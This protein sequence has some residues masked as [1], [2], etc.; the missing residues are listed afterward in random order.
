[1]QVVD[2]VYAYVVKF[3]IALLIV[4]AACVA[5][6]E[7]K[8]DY[9]LKRMPQKSQKSVPWA[10]QPP[11]KRSDQYMDEYETTEE[12]IELDHRPV[13]S[14]RHHQAQLQDEYHEE[15][16]VE[17]VDEEKE[18]QSYKFGF[19]IK[20]EHEGHQYR[21]E[22]KDSKGNIH[23]R[24]GYRD[25]K[26]Q[27][28]QVD[29]VA[30]NHGFRAN[31]KTN[32]PGVID[33]NPANVEIQ[34]DKNEARNSHQID[35]AHSPDQSA[36]YNHEK[37]T[38]SEQYHR[39][40]VKEAQSHGDGA[41][42]ETHHD[43]SVNYEAHSH[44]PYPNQEPEKHYPGK[45]EHSSKYEVGPTA[46][47]QKYFV[48]EGES[49]HE[50]SPPPK[51]YR[52]ETAI[53]EKSHSDDTY[54]KRHPK[55]RKAKAHRRRPSTYQYELDTNGHS[56]RYTKP[57]SSQEYE[58]PQEEHSYHQY[59]KEYLG[60][61]H[62]Q[63]LQNVHVAP[64]REKAPAAEEY[65]GFKNLF[66]DKE[67]EHQHKRVILPQI[68]EQDSHSYNPENHHSQDISEHGYTPKERH[69]VKYE[70]SDD[71]VGENKLRHSE[72][73]RGAP[74]HVPAVN[75]YIQVIEE[76]HQPSPDVY[77][78]E[79]FPYEHRQ[80]QYLKTE[81][82]PQAVVLMDVRDKV[83]NPQKETAYEERNY[84][85]PQSNAYHVIQ[86]NIPVQYEEKDEDLPKP[87]HQES[88]RYNVKTHTQE[89]LKEAVLELNADVYKQLIENKSPGR[90]V[91]IPINHLNNGHL[92]YTNSP[93]SHLHPKPGKAHGILHIP[94]DDKSQS[95][96]DL[97]N[98]PLVLQIPHDKATNYQKPQDIFKEHTS[99]NKAP[100]IYTHNQPF[101]VSVPKA[102]NRYQKNKEYSKS[103]WIPMTPSWN[104][105]RR[106]SPHENDSPV[107]QSYEPQELGVPR[108]ALKASNGE[109]Y[110]ILQGEN[111]EGLSDLHRTPSTLT[112]I[113]GSRSKKVK[114]NL[115]TLSSSSALSHQGQRIVSV[116]RS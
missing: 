114:P 13:D 36:G 107:A 93:Q 31:I 65:E 59:D 17:Y 87:S 101:V 75:Q 3:S 78:K 109:V 37:S 44:H 62:G 46:V 72:V 98:L 34:K 22:Q 85:H 29:Y 94:L 97:K 79:K 111:S 110:Q 86:P 39:Q 61:S 4:N 58:P 8:I 88:S 76:P 83:H 81:P 20:D 67:G 2:M 10:R 99:Q 55:N 92:D 38:E 77:D 64:T 60:H 51:Q 47:V 90:I 11:E 69:V 18:P 40:P 32:E 105:I 5:T 35:V 48:K 82:G 68:A 45:D 89:H 73:H 115:Y 28:R 15:K 33:Q 96:V 25:A 53:Y 91:A 104:Q 26:G 54:E 52:D 74:K 108:V 106:K 113:V 71:T 100:T 56:Y 7:E 24:F 84:D 112:S 1:M 12:R 70:Y 103:K 14:K 42:Y 57:P 21:H 30:D 16:T 66:D 6:A 102:V 43:Q 50:Y 95:T 9:D 41:S 19:E 80:I 27:Y 49:D 63:H 116:H 23:G